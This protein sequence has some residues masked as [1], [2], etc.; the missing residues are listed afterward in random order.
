MKVIRLALVACGL[1]A[2]ALVAQEKASDT[3]LTVNHYLNYESY[4]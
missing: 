2:S 4:N 1:S 3:L